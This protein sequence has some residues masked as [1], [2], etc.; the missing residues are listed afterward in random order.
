MGRG[1]ESETS[2]SLRLWPA[3][4]GETDVG[5]AAAAPRA[6]A[7]VA[8]VQAIARYQRRRE[9]QKSLENFLNK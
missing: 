6:V 5:N 4:R 3:D 1:D 7:R 2:V 9:S 8:N